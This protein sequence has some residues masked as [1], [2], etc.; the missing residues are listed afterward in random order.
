MCLVCSVRCSYILGLSI[1]VADSCEMDHRLFVDCSE[2]QQ[3]A[4]TRIASVYK[5][6]YKT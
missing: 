4:M 6:D 3:E 1:F 2:A 5:R